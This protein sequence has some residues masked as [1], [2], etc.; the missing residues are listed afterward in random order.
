MTEPHTTAA[1]ILRRA[2]GGLVGG[3]GLCW[4]GL[5]AAQ[6]VLTVGIVPQ[7]EAR[8]LSEVWDPV[9]DN[10]SHLSGY[11]FTLIGTSDIPTFER[12]FMAGVYDIA[13]MNP[14]HALMAEKSQGYQPIIR[15]G[16]RQLFGI[17][18]VRNDAP[19]QT[20]DDLAG[21]T[22]AFP[23][24]NALGAALL[25][26]ADLDRSFDLTYTASYVATHSSAY[27]NVFLGEAAAAGGVMSTF[28]SLDPELKSQLRVLYET[29]RVPP[30][31]I[32]VHP[33][34]EPE[35][36]DAIQQA[37]LAMAATQAGAGLLEKIPIK[38]AVVAS[39]GD[40]DVV[41]DLHLDDYVVASEGN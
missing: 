2:L 33:R 14:Y 35:V 13:Y 28:Q 5:A 15:D 41:R 9:L 26:R 17:L 24:P 32:V 20:V 16:G 3:L 19:Y 12:D 29:T 34:V 11:E 30:H 22:I 18:V 37:V 6:Q 4:M 39:A 23:A 36:R 10:L 25:M 31:P 8:Y 40:Y 21:Q 7:F 1:Q 38:S 27:L